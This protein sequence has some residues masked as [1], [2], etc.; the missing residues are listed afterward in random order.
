MRLRKVVTEDGWHGLFCLKRAGTYYRRSNLNALI[1]QKL[2][3]TH[4][5]SFLKTRHL[6]RIDQKRPDDLT[7]VPWA[8]SRQL[9]WDV[10]VV[11]SLTPSTKNAGSVSNPGV[12]AA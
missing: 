11:D 9:L 7:L 2:A 4:I 12:G 10:V 8:V 5:L 3:S 1:K 6:P